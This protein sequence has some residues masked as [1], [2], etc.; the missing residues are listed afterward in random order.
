MIRNE[1][2]LHLVPSSSITPR[3]QKKSLEEETCKTTRW[4]KTSLRAATDPPRCPQRP[5]HQS[6]P[7]PLLRTAGTLRAKLISFLYHLLQP[8]HAAE[9]SRIAEA[10]ACTPPASC[11]MVIERN[12]EE[13]EE[14]SK[15]TPE[16]DSFTPFFSPERKMALLE[17]THE[18]Y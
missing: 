3:S 17:T 9:R 8:P 4:V 5:R 16:E 10:H 15:E 2:F 12:E 1:L 13:K 11:C 18:A 7:R 14:A 6:P